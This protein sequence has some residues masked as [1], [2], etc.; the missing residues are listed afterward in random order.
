MQYAICAVLLSAVFCVLISGGC[1]ARSANLNGGDFFVAPDGSDASSGTMEAPFASLAKAR[2]AV[3]G[4][5]K[6][7]ADR[8]IVVR[9]R[10]GTYR[11]A[12]TVVF[13]LEDSAAAGHTITYAAYPGEKPVLSSGMPVGPWKKL[14]SLP[15]G[16]PDAA[17]GHIWAA[18]FPNGI[19][20]VLSL[21]DGH[22]RLPRARSEGFTPTTK[23]NGWRGEAIEELSTIHFPEGAI[24]NWPNLSDIELLII[25]TCDWSMAILPLASVDE[26][27]KVATT[28]V[29]ASYALAAQKKANRWK[30]TAWI[31]NAPDSM[32]GSGRW[33]ADSTR[34][35]IYYWPKGDQPSDSIA[36]PKLEE[37]IRVEGRIDEAGPTDEPVRGLVFRGI[38]FTQ[39]GRDLWD[40]DHLGKGLQHDWDF[41]DRAN[42]L[43]RLRGAQGCIVEQCRFVD[44]DGGGIRL[45][46][47]CQNNRIE[48]NLVARIGGTG[49][50]LSGYGPGTKDVNHDNQVLRNHIH[51]I[52]QIYWHS[53]GIL[54]TQSG[55]NRIAYNLIHNTPY[56][57]LVLSG[58][59]NMDPDCKLDKGEC[60]GLVRW[61]E[62][63]EKRHHKF[64][65]TIPYL[66][67]RNNV[68]EH[69]EIHDAMERLGDGNGIY[70]SGAGEG[71]IIRYNYIHHVTSEH[72]AGAIRTDACQ[73]GTRFEGNVIYHCANGG[74]IIKDNNDVLNNVIVDVFQ[75]VKHGD[76][77]YIA[78]RGG[79]NNAMKIEHNICL[80]TLDVQ[81]IFLSA[82]A[83][84]H[85]PPTSLKTAGSDYNLFYWMG[86]DDAQEKLMTEVRREGTDAN[87]IWAD[88]K[89]LD[90]QKRDFRVAKDSM[91]VKIGFKPVEFPFPLK[92]LE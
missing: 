21:Y 82:G 14:D 47:Y 63:K 32:T 81:P 28:A 31:E 38:T 89:F 2:E 37:L 27:N 26:A 1:A 53:A 3:G 61:S 77:G 17:N 73:R 50:L 49:I 80:H 57:G 29:P 87:S 39:G 9:L 7:R 35:K 42:A 90:M 59:R 15:A 51:D 45:D 56:N 55:R 33:I 66:H 75:A 8:D 54:V 13:S 64:P 62:V 79:P 70:M 78:L 88:P 41:Y 52:G 11:L 19:D 22:E 16:F 40:A 30:E 71:N 4:L 74:L 34:R 23:A 10:G 67:A 24:R 18:D 91:A 76:R 60:Q 46:L 68:V 12:E 86:H 25:P 65:E 48:G 92:G 83:L 5:K 72:S 44:S 20:R 85:L 69:N 6:E 84:P 43:L 58:I 36:A